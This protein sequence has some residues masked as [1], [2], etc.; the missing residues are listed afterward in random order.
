ML[1]SSSSS[2]HRTVGAAAEGMATTES[3]CTFGFGKGQQGSCQIRVP[4][5]RLVAR[6]PG[7]TRPWTSIQRRP[8][9]PSLRCKQTHWKHRITGV[10]TPCRSTQYS[11]QFGVMVDCSGP[12]PSRAS[13]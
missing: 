1:G 12:T 5:G 4:D 13:P 2:E 6:F 3:S 9:H 7:R 8:D 10:R 11:A